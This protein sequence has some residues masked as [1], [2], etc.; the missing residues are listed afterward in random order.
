LADGFSMTRSMTRVPAS[1]VRDRLARERLR[2]RGEGDDGGL[3]FSPEPSPVS[4][5]LDGES[6]M[7]TAELGSDAN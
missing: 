1:R 3:F 4:T 5:F 2:R 7:A 6:D